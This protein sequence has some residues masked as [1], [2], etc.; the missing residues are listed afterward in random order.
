MKVRLAFVSNS[1]SASFTISKKSITDEE[2][3]S[4]LNYNKGGYQYDDYWD[5]EENEMHVMGYTDM[6]NGDL[7]EYFNSVGMSDFA[8]YIRSD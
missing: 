7:A 3:K 5:I 4:V 6:D 8:C 1:S 2:L